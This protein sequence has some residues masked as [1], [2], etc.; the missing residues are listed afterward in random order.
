MS[1]SIF[2]CTSEP[3]T[4]SRSAP[5]HPIQNREIATLPDNH[6]IEVVVHRGANHLAPENTYAAAAKAIELGVDYVEIDVH[7]SLDGV[8][9]IIHDFTLGRTTDGWGPVRLRNSEY[10]DLLDAGSWFNEAYTG[11]PVPR[12]S[13]YLNW[14]KGKAKVYL[15]VKTADLEEVVDIIRELQMEEDVFFWF[16]NDGMAHKFRELSPDMG[17]K[18]NAGSPEEARKAKAEF[19]ATLIECHVD[20]LTEELKKVCRDLGMR[21]MVYADSNTPEEYERVISSEVD[22]VNLDRPE[23]YIQVLDSIRSE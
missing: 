8:H 4:N 1:F 19:D 6:H 3:S 20:Q 11:E 21:I 7:L 23:L 14:I 9:Y 16:W 22:L 10:I 17:L 2:S 12:L 5:D 18:I 13:E 15:D